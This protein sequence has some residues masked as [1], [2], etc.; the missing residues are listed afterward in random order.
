L[1]ADGLSVDG[2]VTGV[3]AAAAGGLGADGFRPLAVGVAGVA[4][5]ATGLIGALTTGFTAGAVAAA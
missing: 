2:G 3:R 1:G 4:G 5:F